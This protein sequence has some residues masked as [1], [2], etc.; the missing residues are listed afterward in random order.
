VILCWWP[1]AIIG[2][3]FAWNGA[4]QQS[5]HFY[6]QWPSNPVGLTVVVTG[7]V[8][9]WHFMFSVAGFIATGRAI[10][11]RDNDLV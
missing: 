2:I 1:H 5:M 10:Y 11:A 9:V 3:A 8:L 6:R 7:A 4:N